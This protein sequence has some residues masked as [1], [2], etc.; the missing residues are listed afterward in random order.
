MD[1]LEQALKFLEIKSV[2]EEG[3]EE[4]INFLIPLFEQAGAKLVL[5]QVPHSLKDH[6]K[7]QYNLLAIFGDD[8]VDSRTRKGLLMTGSIDTS[9]PG[10]AA[11]WTELGGNP[12]RPK[13]V[14][15]KLFGLG[16]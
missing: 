13:V 16:A 4:A 1:F 12:F 14:G 3:N 11:D 8:L 15:E 7:R 6:A 2:S 5:Q 9:N 10:N